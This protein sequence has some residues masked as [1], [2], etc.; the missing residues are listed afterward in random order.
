MFAFIYI[1]F[2]AMAAYGVVSRSLV[3]YKQVPFN[4]RGIFE[5]IFYPIYWFMHGDVPDRNLLDSNEIFF[6]RKITSILLIFL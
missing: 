3:L 4:A 5:N 6:F 1:I 2:V